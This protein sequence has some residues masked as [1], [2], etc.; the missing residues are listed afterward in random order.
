[1]SAPDYES[2]LQI[3]NRIRRGFRITG[4]IFAA[5]GLAAI[6]APGVATMV[7]EQLVAWLL[8]VWGLAGLMFASSFRAF[9]EWRLIAAGFVAVLVAGIA[10][11]LLPG[12]GAAVLTGALITVFLLEGIVTILLGLRLRGQVSNWRWIIFSGVCSFV[13]GMALLIA[14]TDA[15]RWVIGFM[16]GLNF[17]STGLSLLLLARFPVAR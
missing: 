4:V 16:V 13:L 11:V 3:E 17:L 15:A 6:V 9:S 7:V 1:M 5:L 2:P 8:I 12:A 10:F 14:W